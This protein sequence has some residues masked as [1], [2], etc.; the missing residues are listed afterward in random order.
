MK[1]LLTMVMAAGL[2]GTLLFAQADQRTD[3]AKAPATQPTTQATT[4]PV[5]KM[6]AVRQDEEADPTITYTCNGK[7]YA[8]CCKECIPEFKKNPEKYV[9]AK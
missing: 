7:V 5:N 8:F 4:R 1:A 9:N 3:D 6:C 2:S